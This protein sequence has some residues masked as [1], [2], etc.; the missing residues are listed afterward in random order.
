MK[1]LVRTFGLAVALLSAAAVERAAAQV[2][3]NAKTGGNYMHNYYFAPAASS[4]PWWPS[5][6]PDGKQIAFAMDGSIWTVEV[7]GTVAKELVYSPRE[8]L[9]MPE[10]SPDGK[11]LAYTADDDAKSINLRLLNIA[12]GAIGGPDDRAAREP[13]AGVVAGRPPPGLRLH[14]AQRLLQRLRDGHRRR[15]GRKER[16]DH[17]RPYVRP[18]PSLLRRRRCAHLA[19]VVARRARAAAGVEPRHPARIGRHLAGPGRTQRHGHAGRHADP[20]GRDA[21]PHASAVVARRQADGLRLAPRRAVHRAL[22][23]ADG[24]RRTLQD[25]LRRARPLPAALVA[26]RRVDRL[27][28]ERG[29]RAAAQAA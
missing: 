20:Q 17:D 4:T 18:R 11:W 2:Y 26:R 19:V 8:Y 21:L 27:H 6:S 16:P 24:G 12:T 13:R 9:S 7:G 29:R 28:L 1:T 14:G 23:A 25:D 5:W 22:R 15:Q 3:P 10:Y